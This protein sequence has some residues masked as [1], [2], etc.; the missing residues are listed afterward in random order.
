VQVGGTIHAGAAAI[1]GGA[2]KASQGT[3]KIKGTIKR[4]DKAEIE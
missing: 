1:G 3:T 4:Q 2:L